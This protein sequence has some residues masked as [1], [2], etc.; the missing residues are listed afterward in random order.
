MNELQRLEGGGGA[1]PK[2][3]LKLARGTKF[4]SLLFIGASILI[5]AGIM[6]AANV[7]Y[8]LDSSTIVVNQ[9]QTVSGGIINL[10]ASSNYA[11]NIGT[12]STNAAV[13]IGG[14]SN[15]VEINS[16]NWDV[17]TTGTISNAILSLRAGTAAAGT[18]PLKFATGTNLTAPEAGA[19]EYNG[20][21]LFFTNSTAE[22]F[23]VADIDQD[24]MT[25]Q[26]LCK[27]TSSGHLDCTVDSA[28]VG[29]SALTLAAIGSSANANGMT[30][31][32]Q[33]LNLEP[34]SASFGGV[35]TTGVQTFAGAKTLNSALTIGV[36]STT[37]GDI[38]LY[39][40]GSAF[41]QKIA[42]S[43]ASSNQTYNLPATG[44]TFAMAADLNAFEASGILRGQVN[45]FGFDY[46]AQCSTSCVTPTYNTVSRQIEALPNFPAVL[47][48]ATRTY[49]LVIRYGADLATDGD[50]VTV[51]VYN[52]TTPGAIATWAID[53]PIALGASVEKGY[54]YISPDFTAPTT[55]DW[56]VRVGVPASG[57]VRI[58]S[59]EL[60]AYDIN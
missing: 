24:L 48:N 59:I 46:P 57:I 5:S 31:V 40:A 22:R 21:N 33:A 18:A 60:A 11:V 25:D 44:G 6:Q 1:P 17:S 54:A 29:H 55:D 41:W 43:A 39:N 28:S 13:T 37:S 7:Y 4:V 38:T 34:A 32:G 15:T 8:D 30:L 50:D 26:R 14:N 53:Q 52:I 10:N 45:I 20:T 42:T 23:K 3:K 51:Q 36:A 9:A 27:Y 16:S 2:R 58:Y 12:G 49:R 19:L 35:V 56:E 47:A